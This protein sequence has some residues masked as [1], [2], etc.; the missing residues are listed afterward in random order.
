MSEDASNEGVLQ[1]AMAGSSAALQRVLLLHYNALSRYI[2][3]K[4]PSD[5]Q[6]VV[7]TEDILQQTFTDA[8]RGIAKCRAQDNG[9]FLGWL[10]AIADHRLVDTISTLR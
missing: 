8:F 1:Q 4:V 9:A 3:P 7:G 5:L 10:K 2:T 6:A